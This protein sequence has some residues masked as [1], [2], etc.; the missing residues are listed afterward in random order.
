MRKQTRKVGAASKFTTASK[1]ISHRAPRGK[2]ASGRVATRRAPPPRHLR[3]VGRPGPRPRCRL[4][5][6][7]RRPQLLQSS[8]FSALLRIAI[9]ME[10]RMAQGRKP[11]VQDNSERRISSLAR[12][13][14]STKAPLVLPKPIGAT[15]NVAGTFRCAMSSF[16]SFC[17]CSLKLLW[18]ST[19]CARCTHL[20]TTRFETLET[21]SNEQSSR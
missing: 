1:A 10:S 6:C 14:A 8:C 3:P 4:R 12:A 15:F 19:C 9:L 13:A 5:L 11:F 21:S 16:T 7:L 20:Y 18:T 17:T 2:Q